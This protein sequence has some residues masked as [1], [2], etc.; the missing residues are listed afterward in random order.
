MANIVNFVEVL[1]E[2]G[3]TKTPTEIIDAATVF[4]Q[5]VPQPKNL[6]PAAPPTF[7]ISSGEGASTSSGALAGEA[8]GGG[9]SES[10]SSS[11]QAVGSGEGNSSSSKALVEGGGEGDSSSSGVVSGS[12]SGSGE[13]D[14]N[15]VV[16]GVGGSASGSGEGGSTSN[17]LPV[18]YTAWEDETLLFSYTGPPI[19]E[20]D[21][22][23]DQAGRVVFVGERV[24]A[25]KQEIW[26]YWFN[27]SLGRF[28]FEKITDGRNPRLLLDDPFN[29][30]SSDILLF[31]IN[32]DNE[33]VYRQQ[34]NQYEIELATPIIQE[35]PTSVLYLQ[36]IAK[37]RD[38]RVVAIYALHDI[39]NGTYEYGRLESA[40]YPF[41]FPP[42]ASKTTQQFISGLLESLLQIVSL[43]QEASTALS[44]FLN[45]ALDQIVIVKVL[46]DI[47]A[48]SAQVSI[49][50]GSLD[51]VLL[52]KTLFDI[53][54]STAIASIFESGALDEVV[55][56]VILNDIDS[57]TTSINFQASGSSL[58]IV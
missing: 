51:L 49:Q 30:S 11:I 39:T 29:T 58:V 17:V 12:A 28:I 31:Y 52:V 41:V 13:G 21:S 15:S 32:T 10:S 38:G 53:D 8:A 7:A 1:C 16:A 54:E 18:A 35:S 24:F 43:D 47:D 6:K 46:F 5:P 44:Q 25:G 34:R 14:T 48:S 36:D 40:L 37:T 9:D 57:S 19:V 20:S 56:V 3:V 23:F 2:L 22:A 42:D 45:G 55:I 50:S 27:P 4:R 26:L 33:L